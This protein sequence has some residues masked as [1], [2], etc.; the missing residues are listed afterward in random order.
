MK[1]RLVILSCFIL[2]SGCTVQSSQWNAIK[3]V[4]AAKEPMGESWLL[5]YGGVTS[6]V[7]PITSEALVVFGN[8]NGIAVAFDGWSI[9]SVVGFGPALTV[10]ADS[11]TRVYSRG[12]RT[13]T[14]TCSAWRNIPLA[15][16]SMWEQR[17]ETEFSYENRITLDSQGRIISIDQAVDARGNRLQL[18]KQ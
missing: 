10:K 9:V 6:N 18:K 14:H 2:L 7:V 4:L 5:T 13:V 1:N 15:S 11:D 8:A 12:A 3:D 17:C 16:G